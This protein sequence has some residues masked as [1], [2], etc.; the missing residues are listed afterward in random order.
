MPRTLPADSFSLVTPEALANP[1]PVYDRLRREDPVH[2]SDELRCWVLTR[3]DD[4]VAALRDPRLSSDRIAPFARVQLQ[5][6]DLGMVADYLRILDRTML[7]RDV[8]HHARLRR[9]ASECFTRS[10]LDAWRPLVQTVVD[11]LLDRVAAS[12]RM[13]LVADLAQP[14]PATVMAAMF[15]IPDEHEVAFQQWSDHV[16]QFFGGS[17]GDIEQDARRANHAIAEL[18]QLF[19]RL[20]AERRTSPAQ[21]LIS[22][23]IDSQEHG[24]LDADELTAQCILISVAG[25]VTTIDQLGNAVSTLL[26]VPERWQTL[27]RQPDLLPAAVEETLRHNTSV[28]FIHR[29]ARADLDLGG[30]RIESGHVVFLGL[31]AA[32]HDPEHFAAPERFD[33]TRQP[34]KHLAFGIGPHLCLGAELSRR[35]LEIALHSLLR[36]MPGLRLADQPAELRCENLMFRG[37]KSLPLVF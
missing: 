5:G 19:Q 11:R 14:L 18:E 30:K 2:W 3:Y 36:R 33:M 25:H 34:N 7:M 13:D 4:V 35:E 24:R 17:F 27:V 10:A 16:A 23:L 20:I 26:A 1:Y 15:G 31:A 21:D 29:L 22:L 9:M 6:M 32:N 28:P 12:G 8:P 37:H